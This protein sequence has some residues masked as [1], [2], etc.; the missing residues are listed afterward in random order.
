[1]GNETA[2]LLHDCLALCDHRVTIPMDPRVDSLNLGVA[3][4]IFLYDRIAKRERGASGL[5]IVS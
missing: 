2:G 3:T 5:S 4:S 1:M